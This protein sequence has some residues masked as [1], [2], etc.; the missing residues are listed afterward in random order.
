MELHRS[1]IGLEQLPSGLT[2][3]S[4]TVGGE[5]WLGLQ[6]GQIQKVVA[7]LNVPQAVCTYDQQQFQAQ[8]LT[9]LVSWQQEPQQAWQ[10]TVQHLTGFVP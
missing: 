5:F 8:Q 4:L 1:W 10:A 6:H 7:A 9:G 2:I 3:S